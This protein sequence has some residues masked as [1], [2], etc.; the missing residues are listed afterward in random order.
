MKKYLIAGLMVLV[1][2]F[3][4][5][6]A[7]ADNKNSATPTT[8]NASVNANANFSNKAPMV[9]NINPKGNVMLRG[10][11]TSV[12]TDSLVVKSWGGTWTVKVS[13]TTKIKTKNKLFSDIKEGDFVGVEGNISE[14]GNFVINAR[15]L[16]VWGQKLD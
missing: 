6:V 7:L 12:G 9:I 15:N 10:T 5:V 4:A 13:A 11:V 2:G 3:G 8:S 1:L 16:K 14:D